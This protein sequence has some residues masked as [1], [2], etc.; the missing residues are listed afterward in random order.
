MLEKIIYK[1]MNPQSLSVSN[2][3]R[4]G[5]KRKGDVNLLKKF[6]NKYDYNLLNIN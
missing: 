5:R 2:N 3:F 6:S 1:K 4:F